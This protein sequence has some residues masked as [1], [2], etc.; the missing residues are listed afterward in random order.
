MKKKFSLFFLAFIIL[1][2]KSTINL[3]ALFKEMSIS[4]LANLWFSLF[5]ISISI[6]LM[7]I[8]MYL[9][10]SWLHFWNYG[11]LSFISFRKLPAISS[12]YF[13]TIF[14]LHLLLGCLI[15]NIN[16]FE[17]DSHVPYA[18]CFSFLFFS[19]CSSLNTFYWVVYQLT[20]SDFW[21][22]YSNQILYFFQFCN[23]H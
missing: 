1:I 2:K 8:Y 21:Y 19:W 20:D 14:L 6:S 7:P 22:I 11:G 5:F 17:Y 12:E 23:V 3:I 13:P 16:P 18:I 10:W 9:S 4:V 15:Y